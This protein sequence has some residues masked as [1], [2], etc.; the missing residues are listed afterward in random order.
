MSSSTRLP[1]LQRQR[2]RQR[3]RARLGARRLQP[4]SSLSQR[5]RHRLVSGQPYLRTT[6]ASTPNT[7][8]RWKRRGPNEI[9]KDILSRFKPPVTGEGNF[10][11]TSASPPSLSSV[12]TAHTTTLSSGGEARGLSALSR[13]C[14]MATP[15][16]QATIVWTGPPGCLSRQ[17]PT[18]LSSVRESLWGSSSPSRGGRSN[19]PLQCA[20][21]LIDRM[22]GNPHG[23]YQG[24][25]ESL[26][27]SGTGRS[28]S[29]EQHAPERYR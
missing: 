9:I 28:V 2:T 10:A 17:S 7:L 16:P 6:I 22:G 15:D 5:S 4:S 12:I 21:K 13:T 25:S 20:M 19:H 8:S 1:G 27:L 18:R 3:R 23:F 11:G 29:R 14:G 26:G 24:A